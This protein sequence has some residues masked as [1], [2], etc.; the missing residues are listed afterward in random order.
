MTELPQLWHD[1]VAAHPEH[2]DAEPVV[3]PFGDSPELADELLG[4]VLHG[5]KRATAGAADDLVPAVGDLW[6]VTDGRGEARAI[7]QTTDIRVGR[8]DSVDD[9]FA[10]DEGEGDRSRAHWLDAHRRF[11]RRIL[12][13]VEDIDALETAFERFVVVWP[14]DVADQ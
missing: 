12:P 3:E 2:A 8:L 14:T 13:D 10:Y 4:L 11:F 6:V 9:A 7:L 5:P 1:F